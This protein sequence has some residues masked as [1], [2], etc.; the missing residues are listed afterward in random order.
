MLTIT[1]THNPATDLGFLLH[2]HPDRLQVF[3]FPFGNA[4]VF[5][6]EAD[7]NRCTCALMLDIDPIRLTRRGNT[8]GSTP[9]SL[10]QD[11]VN[12]RPYAAGSH[13]SVVIAKVF[14]TALAGRC[15][16][17]PDLAASPMPL[18]V[19]LTSLRAPHGA[20]LVHR[21]FEPLGYR[22][23]VETPPA[24]PNF[25]QWGDGYHHN[26][27]L[28]SDHLTLSQVLSHLYV[29]TPALDNQKHYWMDRQEAQKLLRFG[30][31]WLARHPDRTLISA[32]Y[33]GH[34][35]TLIAQAVRG[36]EA[37]DQEDQEEPEDY[38]N[39]HESPEDA[40]AAALNPEEDDTP[41]PSAPGPDE[42]TE[43]QLE[44]PMS[45][46]QARIT[47][48]LEELRDSGA[49]TVLDLGCGE[50]ALLRHLVQENRFTS[51]TGVE[52]S[53]M[54]LARAGR[55]INLKNMTP[56]ERQRVSLI[57][58]SLM[59]RDPR[60]HGFDAAV[61]MEV[62][63]HIDPPKVD[64][65]QDAVLAA[66]RPRTLVVTTPNR[67]YNVLFD[68]DPP[69]LRHR[70][71]RFEWTREEFQEWADRAARAHGYRVRLRGI[72]EEHPQH[73]HPTQMAV[74]TR[75]TRNPD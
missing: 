36:L 1:T 55:R 54:R 63:E 27:T 20:H 38:E 6:P 71:H 39:L 33:L 61:A 10:L 47:A 31:D 45:L 49:A 5:Y 26:V 66:A 14:G 70:D 9:E 46:G 32:R 35:T 2:K 42:P 15:Q 51:I 67:E 64:M 60:L 21:M 75:G 56:P 24:D 62:I 17:R 3:E 16:D 19:T 41:A 23:E 43:A 12:D 74:F 48:V 30:Q 18:T 40:G 28:E 4:H 58:G 11:Y 44:R 53:P 72:G 52:V 7:P 8:Q 25:P 13:L 68:S 50:G 59:Y 69:R 65:F 22:V 34:R 57:H 29:L 37:Q 73:G